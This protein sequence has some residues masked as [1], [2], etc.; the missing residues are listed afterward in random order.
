MGELSQAAGMPRG[1]RMGSGVVGVVDVGSNSV[2]LVLY[3]HACRAPTVLFNEK[4]LAA[5]G[6]GLAETGRISDEA[7][8]RALAAI[9]RFMAIVKAASVQDVTIVAT[10]AARD[11]SNG[12]DFIREIE[13]ISGI[14]VRVLDGSEEATMA[15]NGVLCGFWRADGLVGDLGGGSLELIDLTEANLGAGE[16]FPL[17]TLRLK[18]DAKNNLPRGVA[19]LEETL[20]ASRQLPLLAGRPFYAVGGTWRSLVRLHMAETDYPISIMH[21]YSVDAAEMSEF[22]ARLLRD[23]LDTMSHAGVVSKGRRP[24]LPWGAAALQTIIRQG[25]PTSI[26]ASALGVRE[27][28]LYSTLGEAEK[29]RDPLLLA[30][31][32]LALLRS[33][34]PQHSAELVEWSGAV[35][36]ALGIEESEDEQRLRVAAC[37]LSD[38]GWRAHPDYRGD[39]ALAIV[40]N[41]ALYGVDHA[42]RGFLALVLHDRY[43]GLADPSGQHSAD[44][45]CSK[46]LQ[47]R[48]RFLA[49]AFRIAYVLSPGVP[50]ILPRT[51]VEWDGKDF[52]L[53]LPRD[54]AAIEGERPL[55]RMRQFAKQIGGQGMI[56]IE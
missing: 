28:L 31:E 6:E 16:S 23:G 48:A 2:R 42:G 45:L 21:H 37:L 19:I 51:R 5:L 55:R 27:G 9:R 49:A 43:G 13:A 52:V 26:V 44:I 50:G 14:G 38:I 12:P 10:A 29:R 33:R 54:L 34:S 46:A 40:S 22:C 30:T 4:V 8:E 36:R 32:E 3:E 15:A 24:L 41:A 7:M 39:Q 47:E 18:G 53:Y 17:G 11:A 35:F 25:R 1:R 20:G 56:R